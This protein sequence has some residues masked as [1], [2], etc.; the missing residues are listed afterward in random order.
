MHI[1]FCFTHFKKRVGIKTTVSYEGKKKYFIN[2]RF[3]THNSFRLPL[4]ERIIIFVSE[5][6]IKNVTN[7]GV[8]EENR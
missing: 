4:I 6:R 2:G 5:I 7:R 8:S 3:F 1:I